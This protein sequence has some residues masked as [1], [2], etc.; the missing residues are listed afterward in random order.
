M[1]EWGK[2]DPRWIVEDRPDATNPNN[3]HWK[4]KN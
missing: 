3:W 4:E 1:A 2:G